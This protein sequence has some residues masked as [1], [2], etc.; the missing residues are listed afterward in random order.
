MEK[1]AMSS[2]LIAQPSFWPE[3]EAVK[4]ASKVVQPNQV[5]PNQVQ[6]KQVQPKQVKPKLHQADSLASASSADLALAALEAAD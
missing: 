4:P 3:L 5:Q 2:D 1:Q 6:P